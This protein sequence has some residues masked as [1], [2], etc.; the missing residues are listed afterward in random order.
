MGRG[1]RGAVAVAAGAIGG[2]VSVSGADLC[3][4]VSTLLAFWAFVHAVCG[5]G[6]GPSSYPLDVLAQDHLFAAPALVLNIF[7]LLLELEAFLDGGYV[8]G[9]DGADGLL[10]HSAEIFNFEEV[11]EGLEEVA[12]NDL[13]ENVADEGFDGEL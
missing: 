13:C 5:V 6:G 11:A 8:F 2:G 4:V 10:R 1:G 12:L 9:G 7:L 3:W